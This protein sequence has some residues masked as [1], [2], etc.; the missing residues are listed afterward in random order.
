MFIGCSR[1]ISHYFGKRRGSKIEKAL[2]TL[3]QELE[4][5]CD[6]GFSLSLDFKKD[7]NSKDY[8]CAMTYHKD[9]SDK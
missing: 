8:Y 1:D 6:N 2:N 3:W 9:A 7:K 4:D 5:G